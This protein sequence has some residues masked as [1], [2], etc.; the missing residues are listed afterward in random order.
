MATHTR[1]S[2][3]STR[4][5]ISDGSNVNVETINVQKELPED[6]VTKFIPQY[7]EVDYALIDSETKILILPTKIHSK[8]LNHVNML[9]DQNYIK[10]FSS[11]NGMF[12]SQGNS[13]YGFSISLDNSSIVFSDTLYQTIDL[14]TEIFLIYTPA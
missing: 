2:Q 11:Y 13:L 3:A 8:F 1:N 10:R 5:L 9:V 7:V 12:D 14:T 6:I 4:I